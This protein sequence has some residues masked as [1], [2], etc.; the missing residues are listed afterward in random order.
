MSKEFP[1]GVHPAERK[2]PAAGEAPVRLSP[3][4]VVIPMSQHIGA[5]CTPAVKAGDHVLIGQKV[6]DGEG[7]CVPVHASVSGTVTAVEPRLHVNGREVLSV[8]IENDFKNETV[9]FTP[10]ESSE[11][12]MINA[13]REAGIA[14]M[15]GATFPT[16]AKINSGLGKVD[17]VII[18]GCECEPYITSDDCLMQNEAARVMDG[19]K[20]LSQLLN[21][22]RTVVAVE[23]NK[24][25]AIASL[26]AAGEIEVLPLRTRYPQGAEKQ[27]IYA[28]TKREV[29]AG[30]L[31][32]DAGSAVFNV[33]TAAAVSD[34]IRLGKPLTERYV[35]VAGDGAQK[36]GN[37]IVPLG[38]PIEFV[39]ESAGGLAKDCEKLLCGGPMMGVAQATDGASV[40]K[41][42]NCLL[43]LKHEKISVNDPTCIRCGRCV[44]ACPMR[45]LP[46]Y[47]ALACKGGDLKRMKKLQVMSC[48]ECGCC[49]YVCPAKI[50]LTDLFKGGKKTI[51][52]SE[53]PRK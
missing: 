8:V 49:T 53:A 42:T 28:V 27:L 29:P 7:L 12:D 34:A 22:K 30:K 5:P 39:L 17:T 19:A 14:G 52:E 21:A 3:K 25:A 50:P 37:F 32:A 35:S 48:I 4:T 44:S 47:M 24:L 23:A 36:T 38:T 33:S 2:S 20:L 45:L 10:P 43:C 41:G 40:I 15:G 13:V 6:G 51:K 26:K 16:Y 9:A 11:I 1:G 18:N 31:P 46:N